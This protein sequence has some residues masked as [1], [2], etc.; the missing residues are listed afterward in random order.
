MHG[1]TVYLADPQRMFRDLLQSALTPEFRVLGAAGDGPGAW[2]AIS[3]NPPELVL[4]EVP[5]DG[6]DGFELA[7]RIKTGSLPVKIVFVS[8]YPASPYA[9]EALSAGAS[10]YVVKECSY[11]QLRTA[12]RAVMLGASPLVS[13]PQKSAPG[14][15]AP[16]LKLSLRQRDILHLISRGF[17]VKEIANQLCISSKTVEYHKACIRRVSG[18]RSTAELT[19]LAISS[20]LGAEN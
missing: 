11:P 7:R 1:V 16:A 17:S 14:S 13:L 6:F 4:L 9:G 3:R 20:S 18:C 2:S 10:A 8:A 12:I 15:A 5:L 19:R